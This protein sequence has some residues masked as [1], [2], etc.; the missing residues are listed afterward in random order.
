MNLLNK[1]Q[2]QIRSSHV[3]AENLG[4][5]NRGQISWE[6]FQELQNE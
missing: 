1:I 4:S 2:R 3:E 5:F 6:I